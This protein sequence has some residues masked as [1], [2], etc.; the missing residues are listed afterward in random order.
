MTESLDLPAPPPVGEK[1]V[2]ILGL[3]AEE[4]IHAY[5]LEDK[6]RSRYMN[7]WT[8]IG[9]SSIYRVL[10]QLEEKGLIDSRLE[11]EGQGATRKV[12][13]LNQAGLDALRL[14]VLSH[15]A[16]VN[17]IK[18]PFQVGL[19]FVAHVPRNELI[20]RLRARR[21][22]VDRWMQRVTAFLPDAPP[23][24]G[25]SRSAVMCA[26][27]DLGR[28]LVLDHAIRHIHAERAFLDDTLTALEQQAATHDKEVVG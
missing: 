6:I 8:D 4:P 11:H 7:E 21:V 25:V 19:A 27:C 16:T 1:H 9:F 18:N 5:G 22:E 13:A 15:L 20:E 3:I 12:Y 28:S 24:S 17:P 10:S 14:G 23:Q 2:V 26:D